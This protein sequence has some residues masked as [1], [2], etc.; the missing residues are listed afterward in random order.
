LSS[1]EQPIHAQLRSLGPLL[2]WAIVYADIGTSIYYVPGILFREVGTSAATYVLAT[3]LAFVLLSEKYSEIASRYPGGG[4]VVSVAEEAFGART[5]A[6]GGMLILVDYFLTAAI[7]SISGFVY[8]ASLLPTLHGYEMPLAAAGIIL[9][10]ILNWVGIRES[11]QASAFVGTAAF[12]VLMILIGVT[13]WKIGPSDWQRI[14]EAAGTAG[15]IPIAQAVTGYAAAWLAFSGLESLAQI[16]PAMAQPR[17]RTAAIAMGLVVLAVLATSPI[18]TAMATTVIDAAH[19]NPDAFQSELAF[20]MGGRVLRVLVVVTASA[21]LCLRRT[22]PSSAPITWSARSPTAASCRA[23]CCA[24]RP[25]SERR[26]SR[27]SSPPWC[28]S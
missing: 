14:G 7:S 2:C 21:L 4:G 11:A 12:A 22:P 27:S 8:L 10:G 16:S 24:A 20:A 26:T 28:R 3:S 18:L 19:A 9:L 1:R 5:G 6:L 15:R 23:S 13:A 25:A 17:R